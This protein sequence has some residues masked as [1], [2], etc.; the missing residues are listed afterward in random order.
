M[1]SY[2]CAPSGWV[3]RHEHARKIIEALRAAGLNCA[4]EV[5]MLIPNSDK[6]PR[7]LFAYLEAPSPSN[8]VPRNTAMDVKIRSSRVAA[9]RWHAAEKP[10]GSAKFAEQKKR[11]D[12]A[13]AIAAAAAAAGT[14]V[15]TLLWEFQPLRFEQYDASGES[16]LEFLEKLSIRIARGMD[17]CPGAALR[18]LFRVVSYSIWSDQALAV[19]ARQRS[20]FASPSPS[21]PS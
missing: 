7:D 3:S 18:R 8:P 2:N 1:L 13:K 17:C 15:P 12:L 9:R 21:M 16:T 19:L 20:T 4:I 6:R 11:N 10:G 14:P 5:P